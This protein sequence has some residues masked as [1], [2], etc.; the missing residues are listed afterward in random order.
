MQ[1][2]IR[3][4]SPVILILALD[5]TDAREQSL[6]VWKHGAVSED[7][8]TT[9]LALALDINLQVIHCILRKE[10]R[11]VAYQ[12]DHPYKPNHVTIAME[13]NDGQKRA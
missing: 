5:E 6:D 13:I 4:A 7:A 9:V 11:L 1:S 12:S 3:N 8:D 10:H 2:I